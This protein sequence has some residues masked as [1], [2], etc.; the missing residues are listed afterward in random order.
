M[1]EKIKPGLHIFGHIHDGYGFTSNGMTTFIN[2]SNCD[3]LY[4]PVNKPVVYE[5][6]TDYYIC[7]EQ[8][9]ICK[10]DI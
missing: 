1:I 6:K 9:G 8:Y 10:A 3:R 2:A 7:L 4:Q 5:Y